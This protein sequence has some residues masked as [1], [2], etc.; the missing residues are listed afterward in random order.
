MSQ[1]KVRTFFGNQMVSFNHLDWVI[2]SV[3]KDPAYWS[4]P[5]YADRHALMRWGIDEDSFPNRPGDYPMVAERQPSEPRL[6]ITDY[7]QGGDIRWNRWANMLVATNSAFRFRTCLFRA[8]DV[9]TQANP[10]TPL[11]QPLVCMWWDS[12]Y[13]YD[14]VQQKMAS[15]ADATSLC[16]TPPNVST[17]ERTPS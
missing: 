10:D 7:P 12:L 13:V 4:D 8:G 1:P 9:P 3:D 2:D 14:H 5:E 17:K 15:P 16:Q 11:P 6:F